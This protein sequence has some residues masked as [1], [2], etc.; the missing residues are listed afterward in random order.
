MFGP[1]DAERVVLVERYVVVDKLCVDVGGGR[2]ELSVEVLIVLIEVV[3][4]LEAEVEDEVAS[5]AVVVEVL[6]DVVVEDDVVS[7]AVVVTGTVPVIAIE[8]GMF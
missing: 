8:E 3:V 7:L 1:V 2:E 4:V 5:S 6:V